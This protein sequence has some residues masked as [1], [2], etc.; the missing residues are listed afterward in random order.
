MKGK[1][2]ILRALALTVAL[3]A[4]GQGAWATTKTVTYTM[5]IINNLNLNLAISGDIPFDG[6][7]TIE[8]RAYLNNTVTTFTLADGFSFFFRWTTPLKSNSRGFYHDDSSS[9]KMEFKVTWDF[10]NNYTCTSSLLWVV[11][12]VL[13]SVLC[14]SFSLVFH[15]H[16]FISSRLQPT[17]LYFQYYLLFLL[18]SSTL[19]CIQII[20]V[21]FLTTYWA[22]LVAQTVKNLPEM[23]ET[24]VQ[25]LG[26]EEPLEKGM[27]THSCL[28]A[29]RI[30]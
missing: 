23:Q 27:A 5:S 6:T 13:Y 8:S 22:S 16:L 4:A 12:K 1:K 10:I 30:P 3:L 21:Y 11:L 9:S 19:I 15:I 28:L 29:W 17:S 18:L 25:F 7:T 24:R 2:K 20:Y 26:W 14:S